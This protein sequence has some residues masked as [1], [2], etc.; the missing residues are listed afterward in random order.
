MKWAAH[1]ESGCEKKSVTGSLG[2][3]GTLLLIAPILLAL[4]APALR[5]DA[6]IVTQAMKASTILELFGALLIA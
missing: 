1:A 2:K 6:I 5:A 3:L 4:T